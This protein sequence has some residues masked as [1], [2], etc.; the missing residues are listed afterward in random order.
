ME[1]E[2]WNE[3]VSL[4][5]A[6]DGYPQSVCPS[7]QERFTELLVKSLQGKG[8][9][10]LTYCNSSC[11][12]MTQRESLET[13]F[14]SQADIAF[15]CDQIKNLLLE[16]NMKYGDAALNPVRIFSKSD[17][18]EQLNVRIDDKLNRIANGAS[19]EDEDPEWDLLGYLI[20]KR[21]KSLQE[22]RKLASK[23]L[24]SHLKEIP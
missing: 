4:K 16:K 3:L 9:R 7:R 15:V 1:K 11:T 18:N 24:D 21:V 8:D 14:Q 10:P 23:H 19:N 20:L 13:S 5:Q 17:S 6:I 12:T 2:E 22:K